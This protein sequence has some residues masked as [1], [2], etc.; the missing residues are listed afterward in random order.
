MVVTICL[1]VCNETLPCS[2]IFAVSP[3]A[4]EIVVLLTVAGGGV[5]TSKE[6]AGEPN[7]KSLVRMFAI[8]TLWGVSLSTQFCADGVV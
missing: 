2:V 3:G 4:N 1:M 8:N 6:S 5:V 7:W